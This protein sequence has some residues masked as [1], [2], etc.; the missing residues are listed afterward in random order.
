MCIRDSLHAT[1][2]GSFGDVA[3]LGG[4]LGMVGAAVLAGAAAL[5]AGA[6]RVYL[7]LL[8]GDSHDA[9]FA[10]HPVLMQRHLD[11][12][13]LNT[14]TLVAGCGGGAAIAQHLPQILPQAQGLV[15]DADALNALARQ[16]D[17]AALL[18]HRPPS[19]TVLTPHP[20]EAARLL[21]CTTPQIQADRLRHAQTLSDLSLI[22]I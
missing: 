6:G 3:I 9:L 5:H 8:A 17:G 16:P 14:L 21:G 1:H 15:L 2:K 22:H 18:R 10:T 13:P 19:S 20:L 12:L 4:D 11:H 7:S